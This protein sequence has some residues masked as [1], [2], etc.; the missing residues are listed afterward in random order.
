M[1]DDNNYA[2]WW[3]QYY[4]L[5]Y[6]VLPVTGQVPRLLKWQQWNT[7]RLTEDDIQDIMNKY[8]EPITGLCIPLGPFGGL[9]IDID[10]VAGE[11]VVGGVVGN[12]REQD[13]LSQAWDLCRHSPMVKFGSKGFTA[14]F[15]YDK[16]VASLKSEG[17]E[18]FAQS[19][20]VVV[21]PSVHPKTGKP[22]IWLS[23]TEAVALDSLPS[24][25]EGVAGSRLFDELRALGSKR[26]KVLGSSRSR[27]GGKGAGV[28]LDGGRNNKLTAMAW[29]KA[30]AFEPVHSASLD[31]LRYDEMAH[32]PP[33]FSDPSE[34]KD[35]RTPQQRAER[36]YS[37]AVAKMETESGEVV[38]A[39]GEVVE[40]SG[41]IT[42]SSSGLMLVGGVGGAEGAEEVIP[43]EDPFDPIDPVD[44]DADIDF[45]SRIRALSQQLIPLFTEGSLLADFRTIAGTKGGVDVPA[46]QLSAGLSLCSLCS[47][48]V[49]ECG[50]MRANEMF[51]S[52]S[53]SGVGKNAP[54]T[55][56]KEIILATNVGEA[57]LGQGMYRS[58]VAGVLSDLDRNLRHA[59]LDILDEV[60][61]LFQ[62]M[63]S[64][65]DFKQA[66]QIL[67]TLWSSATS[68][69]GA[70]KVMDAKKSFGAVHNPYHVFLGSAQPS[71]I[72]MHI[73]PEMMRQG[74][75]PRFLWFI[76]AV[77]RGAAVEMDEV[78]GFKEVDDGGS[79][80]VAYAEAMA[81][82]VEAVD[83]WLSMPVEYVEDT[84]GQASVY[85][86]AAEVGKPIKAR[87]L[88]PTK[89][90]MVEMLRIQ[91]E[92]AQRAEDL[93]FISDPME[94]RYHRRAEHI[95]RLA[96]MYWL[97]TDG[98]V[99]ALRGSG[100]DVLAKGESVLE[101]EH[102]MWAEKVF[103]IQDE[104]FETLMEMTPESL[105]LTLKGGQVLFAVQ[106]DM[107]NWL[108][109]RRSG[110]LI[111]EKHVK[112]QFKRIVA[113]RDPSG[114][115]V[116]NPLQT[117]DAIRRSLLGEGL[118]SIEPG[119]DK[120]A[121][122]R[123]L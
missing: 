95:R 76:D 4:E 101:V 26:L 30:K 29:A 92:S 99:E 56:L 51:L 31:L 36:L 2:Q 5:G 7:T 34:W 96:I 80:A 89:E 91:K 109:A 105:G 15:A 100:E 69:L 67:A 65:T 20:Q 12:G 102:I 13:F 79:Q 93:S 43:P 44:E 90:A 94:G 23:G 118:I 59:K 112:Q 46:L 81:R 3:A 62:K 75:G 84:K 25:S 71:T 64:N 73:K 49:L 110:K 33:Y 70:M 72:R 50:Q 115:E 121:W 11:G 98:Y 38:L 6:N 1:T 21:P 107:V 63:D 78:Y 41:Q 58:I 117:Y 16:S 60:S 116:R 27:V 9:A 74:L 113:K 8:K 53:A 40:A 22:Y 120:K 10:M 111:M 37:R 32:N 39:S 17:V 28:L 24:W 122:L 114:L 119:V 19:G 42:K 103:N 88:R 18:L 14:F 61:E 108:R 83:Y 52:L 85:S 104:M 66:A 68:M 86:K 54:Q 47:S 35:S 123:I 97:A 82:I 106:Q 87:Q 55:A 48:N 57:Y 45:N 77:P